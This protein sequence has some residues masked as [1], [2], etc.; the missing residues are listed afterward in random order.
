M[1]RTLEIQLIRLS[2]VGRQLYYSSWSTLIVTL[3]KSTRMSERKKWKLDDKMQS[4]SAEREARFQLWKSPFDRA[5]VV[6]NPFHSRTLSHSRD[7]SNQLLASNCVCA[8]RKKKSRRQ[9]APTLLVINFWISRVGRIKF[10]LPKKHFRRVKE[11]E[12]SSP[13]LKKRKSPSLWEIPPHRQRTESPRYISRKNIPAR[14]VYLLYI[15]LL[16]FLF[17]ECSDY[18]QL[19]FIFTFS[20]WCAVDRASRVRAELSE[21]FSFFF[22]VHS[23]VPFLIH[24]VE[25]FFESKNVPGLRV[26]CKK[27]RFVCSID[28]IGCARWKC[29]KNGHKTLDDYGF[30]SHKIHII[31]NI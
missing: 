9:V 11:T 16:F 26:S 30:T 23:I 18:F 29:V 3:R 28:S 20:L 27:Q 12:R 5:A 7:E 15:S 8:K 17:R 13:K 1:R 4:K 25:F 6:K 22:F 31:E 19:L 10:Q 2:Y 24:T 21:Y 14:C